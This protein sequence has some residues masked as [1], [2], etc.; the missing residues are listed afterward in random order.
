MEIVCHISNISSSYILKVVWNLGHSFVLV[1]II[2]DFHFHQLFLC[3][4]WNTAPSNSYMR[5]LDYTLAALQTHLFYT[6]SISGFALFA[7]TNIYRWL[8]TISVVFLGFWILQSFLLHNVF[9][10]CFL[11]WNLILQSLI[12]HCFHF[13][14][15]HRMVTGTIDKI[16]FKII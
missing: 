10:P 6:P 2:W 15:Y 16:F 7:I 9:S 3:W 5:L 12:N 8:S 13:L 11:Q 14:N 1:H 4:I